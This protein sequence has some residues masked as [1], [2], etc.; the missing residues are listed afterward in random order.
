MS[1]DQTPNSIALPQDLYES[2][3]SLSIVLTNT[4]LEKD[5]QAQWRAYEALQQFCEKAAGNGRNHP[6]LWETLADFTIDNRVAIALYQRSLEAS[7]QLGSSG[8]DGTTHFALALRYHDL[9]DSDLAYE[10][11][12]AADEIAKR[13]SDL[14]LRREI[15]RFLLGRRHET[16][17]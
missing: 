10:H 14:S 13:T 11:A 9:G 7:A 16:I 15:S 3:L 17:V 1:I 6:F 4:R 8:V 2:V 12:T 5:V